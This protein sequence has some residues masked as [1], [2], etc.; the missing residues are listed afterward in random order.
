MNPDQLEVSIR[1]GI[2]YVIKY[3]DDDE[4]VNNLLKNV[5]NNTEVRKTLLEVEGLSFN[6]ILDLAKQNSVNQLTK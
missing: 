4:V 3:P 5:V 2:E 6:L 1:S